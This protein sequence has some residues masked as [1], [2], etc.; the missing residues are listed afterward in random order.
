MGLAMNAK[1]LSDVMATNALRIAEYLL[2]GG[3]KASGEWKCGDIGGGAGQ[4]L[5]VRVSGSK[6]GVWSDF[7]S[8]EGG[9]LLDL[10]M[11]VRSCDL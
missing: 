10:W 3:K 9:D 7:A 1:E 8:G 2:P 6:S 11:A 5:G 4:S